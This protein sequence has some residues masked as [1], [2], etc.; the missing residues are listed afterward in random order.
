ML[1]LNATGIFCGYLFVT[2]QQ[3]TGVIVLGHFPTYEQIKNGGSKFP[4]I[5]YGDDNLAIKPFS[6]HLQPRI[7]CL[8][9]HK[10]KEFIKGIYKKLSARSGIRI[11]KLRSHGDWPWR[12]SLGLGYLVNKM[13]TID[14]ALSICRLLL[15]SVHLEKETV[16][17]CEGVGLYLEQFN[18]ENSVRV[19]KN[20]TIH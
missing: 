11:R 14:T 6:C 18:L 20:E 15:T 13:G 2:R 4:P 19:E 16:C 5:E 8:A 17:G 12:T 7:P 9:T 3:L 10:K 1:L